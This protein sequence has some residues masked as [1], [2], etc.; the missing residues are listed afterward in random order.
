MAISL[1]WLFGFADNALLRNA[2][3]II[4]AF[5]VCAGLLCQ[6]EEMD[7]KQNHPSDNARYQLRQ[8]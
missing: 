2:F 1:P 3:V 7:S 8:R 6:P 5:G 4:S